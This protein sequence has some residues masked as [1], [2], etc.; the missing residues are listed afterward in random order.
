[1]CFIIPDSLL[2]QIGDKKSLKI[3][4]KLR[5]A[6]NSILNLIF[7]PKAVNTAG[8]DRKTYDC[9]HKETLP[10]KLVLTEEPTPNPMFNMNSILTDEEVLIAHKWTGVVYDFYSQVLGRNSL[11]DKGMTLVS[12]VKYG[13]DYNNAFWNSKQMVYGSGDGKF[14]KPLV[15]DLSVAGHEMT[16]GV[17][18]RTCGLVYMG[19]SGALNEALAD[20]FGIAIEHWFKG[21]SDP[22]QAGWI[23]GDD[24]IGSEFPGKGIRSFVPNEKAYTGDI[25]PSHMKDY[26]RMLGDNGG[27]HINSKIPNVVF[28]RLCLLMSEPSYGTPIKLLYK[29]MLKLGKYSNFKDY[30]KKLRETAKQEYG[31]RV[32]DLV[33]TALRDTG[34]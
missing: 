16:H 27:V 3:S 18:E 13:Q 6:R 33:D 31:A 24:M 8:K 10:G 29:T 21:Q 20:C 25:Q 15:R 19:Q 2:G 11:D 4:Q 28:F 1:M 34:L 12:S 17:V 7:K 5:G 22:R 14:F 9:N 26:K 30:A 32:Y 23:L